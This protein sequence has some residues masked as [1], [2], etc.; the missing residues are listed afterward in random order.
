MRFLKD[1]VEVFKGFRIDRIYQ[2]NFDILPPDSATCAT[3][4]LEEWHK[5][6]G[7]TSTETIK[8]MATKQVVLRLDIG[9]NLKS[10]CEDC[11]INKCQATSHLTRTTPKVTKAGSSLHIDTAGPTKLPGVGE[12]RFILIC[13]DEFSGFR[14]VK[15]LRTKSQITDEV[16]LMINIAELETGNSVL[17]INRD[18]GTEFVDDKLT[19]FLRDQGIMHQL[20]T[21]YTPQQNGT[22]EREIRTMVDAARTLLN[23]ASLPHTLWPEAI[24]SVMLSTV[25]Q[26]QAAILLHSRNGMGPNQ[27]SKIW[28]F[29]DGKQLC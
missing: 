21:K 20:S 12:A 26:I 7:R 19:K 10:I 18:N 23:A 8:R 2:I 29:L 25:H 27:M 4:T 9:Q 22:V 24:Y 6:F 15:C 28:G 3:A 5:R 14:Q 1:G 17:K 11:V 13:K 16:K